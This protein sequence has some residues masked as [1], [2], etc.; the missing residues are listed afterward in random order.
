MYWQN[1][2]YNLDV[3]RYSRGVAVLDAAAAMT[4]ESL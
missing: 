2:Y 4:K 1:R 3:Y